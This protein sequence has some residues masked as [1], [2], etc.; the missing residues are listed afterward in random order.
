[1][2]SFQYVQLK[3]SCLWKSADAVDQVYIKLCSQSSKDEVRQERRDR[4]ARDK[5]DAYIPSGKS[6]YG[7]PLI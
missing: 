4:K 1:M 7:G 5:A 6:E 2:N 3:R